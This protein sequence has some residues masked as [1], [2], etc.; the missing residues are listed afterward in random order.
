MN[1]YFIHNMVEDFSRQLSMIANGKVVDTD[2]MYTVSYNG[3][4]RKN[5]I[6]KIID[7][8]VIPVSAHE[9]ETADT[10]LYSI[11]NV[12]GNDI[13][14]E[15]LFNINNVSSVNY[16]AMYIERK[17]VGV[18]PKTL[19]GDD[20]KKYINSVICMAIGFVTDRKPYLNSKHINMFGIVLAVSAIVHYMG[21]ALTPEYLGD[22]ISTNAV[23]A[24]K[25]I[26]IYDPDLKKFT[27]I[28]W[29]II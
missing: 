4:V 21:V 12:D 8:H 14:K 23:I 13:P 25:M 22:A 6:H 26:T 9:I 19:T 15:L 18:D 16:G 24:E 10:S 27:Q 5:K 1:E 3:L 28:P 17:F 7:S 29:R 20:L 11:E 2:D